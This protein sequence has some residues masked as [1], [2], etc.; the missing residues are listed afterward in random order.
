MGIFGFGISLLVLAVVI[1]IIVG[2]VMLLKRAGGTEV[3]PGIGTTRR[4][5]LYGLAFV[6]LMLAASGLTFLMADVLDSLVS[7]DII[8]GSSER[9]AFGLAAIIVGFPIWA[10]LWLAANRS[11]VEYPTEAGTFGRK[12]Y[13]FGVLAVSAAV[14]ASYLSLGL[15]D[16]V[17]GNRIGRVDAEHLLAQLVVFVCHAAVVCFFGD[18]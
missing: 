7:D 16:V 10:L 6:A 18:L 3:A 9:T 1:G 4:V 14:V 15:R 2:I 13:S 12:L 11:L 17:E 8:G 5:F